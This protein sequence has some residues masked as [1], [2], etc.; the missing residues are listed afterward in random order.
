MCEIT[1][2]DRGIP[3]PSHWK[4]KIGKKKTG[5]VFSLA[6]WPAAQNLSGFP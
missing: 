3:S 1:D 6:N 5:Q 2:N 4:R